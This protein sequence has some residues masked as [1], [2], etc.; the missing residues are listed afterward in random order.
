MINSPKL[1]E[2]VQ[3]MKGIGE[4][5][6]PFNFPRV[7]LSVEDEL[8]IF[9]AREAEIDGYPL[10]LHYQK[11]DYDD[12]FIETLQIHNRRGPFLPFN[13]ICKLGTKFLGS[14]NLSLIE[15][16]RENR[17][18]YV[19]SKCTDKNGRTIPIPNQTISENCEYEGLQ[20]IYVQPSSVDFL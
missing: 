5:L 11:S 2:I 8:G 12:Y 9:K 18:V 7:P 16:F 6:V 15:V 4:V 14:I 19:W 3:I 10:F 1:S 13:L 20:Y 17:K